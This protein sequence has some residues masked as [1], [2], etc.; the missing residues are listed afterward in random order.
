MRKAPLMGWNLTLTDIYFQRFI[1][2]VKK[3]IEKNNDD[4]TLLVVGETGT[5]KSNIM[6]EG[7][8][9]YNPDLDMSFVGLDPNDHAASLKN[10]KDYKGSRFCAMD[11]ANI[12]KRDAVT[13]YNK[14]LISV[15]LAIRGL[16]IF[17]WWNNPSLDIIDKFFIQEKINAVM[18]IFTKG[19]P[20]RYYYLFDKKA[21]LNIYEKNKGKLTLRALTK[22]KELALYMGWF[23]KY[24]GNL[25]PAYMEKKSARMDVKVNE[26]FDEFA[27]DEKMTNI[28][29][30]KK[31]DLSRTGVYRRIKK[32]QENGDWIEGEDCLTTA[33]KTYVLPKGLEKLDINNFLSKKAD[34]GNK[35]TTVT[36]P[37]LNNHAKGVAEN[38]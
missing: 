17:H 15:F 11:E 36:N 38:D 18:F 14:R 37:P 24:E 27:D 33:S 25:L 8:E 26:F 13:K 10:A 22:Y 21:I 6:L 19:S 5:G 7:M 34:V 12:S 3:R 31:L 28:D 2:T 4:F 1:K 16:N 29:V 30:S 9:I 23:R 35:I 20:L 32:F